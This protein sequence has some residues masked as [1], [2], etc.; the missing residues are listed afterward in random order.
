MT[1]FHI[2]IIF[3]MLLSICIPTYNR[4]DILNNLLVFL[5]EELSSFQHECDIEVI[6]S[7]NCSSDHTDEVVETFNSKPHRNILFRYNKNNVNIGIDNNL[8]KLLELAEGE[9]LWWMGDDDIYHPGVVKRVYDVITERKY[10]YIFINHCGIKNGEIIMPTA[11]EGIDYTRDDKEVLLDIFSSSGPTLMFISASVHKRQH[12]IEYTKEKFKKDNTATA[13]LFAFYS[14]SQ[15]PVKIIEEVLVEDSYDN[16]SWSK[17]MMQVFKVDIPYILRQLPYLGYSVKWREIYI[18]YLNKQNIPSSLTS[19][20]M[21]IIC[22][23]RYA[24][25]I[26]LRRQFIGFYNNTRY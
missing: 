17:K 26:I 3:N 1:I 5:E 6:V 2:I 24:A 10:S 14:A 22:E 15:G 12:L 16:I 20:I 19:L 11:I 9:Y 23:P 25:K 4:A 7:N 8:F 18:E 21:K 13:L